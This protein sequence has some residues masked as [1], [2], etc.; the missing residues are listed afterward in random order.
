MSS[1]SVACID[2][3]GQMYMA[4]TT[5][6]G[7]HFPTAAKLSC[8][9]NHK[10]VQAACAHSAVFALA[11]TGRV[12]AWGRCA[13]GLLGMTSRVAV[14]SPKL[15]KFLTSGPSPREVAV[16][17]LAAGVHHCAAISDGAPSLLCLGASVQPHVHTRI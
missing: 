8:L 6:D 5:A 16:R 13:S 14:F 9:N 2:G 7:E 3:A 11:D 12:M 1:R 10:V 15:L 4:G 17:F